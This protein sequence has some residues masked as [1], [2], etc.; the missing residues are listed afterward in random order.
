VKNQSRL[1][2]LFYPTKCPWKK[3]MGQ[4]ISSLPFST[5]NNAPEKKLWHQKNIFPV[6]RPMWVEFPRDEHTFDMESQFMVGHALLVK[7][8][9][10]EGAKTT[11]IYLPEGVRERERPSLFPLFAVMSHGCFNCRV[12]GIWRAP[13][14]A[15]VREMS[16]CKL[17]WTSYQFLSEQVT[18]HF[19]RFGLSLFPSLRKVLLCPPK[20]G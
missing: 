5:P 14:T 15:R 8:V 2:P 13:Y 9:T 19:S 3:I 12:G 16:R 20:R 11:D 6:P 4:K 7:P 18:A 10:E 17:R 1:R